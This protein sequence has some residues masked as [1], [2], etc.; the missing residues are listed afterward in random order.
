MG[1]RR[2]GIAGRISMTSPQEPIA[3]PLCIERPALVHE[4]SAE[5][6]WWLRTQNEARAGVAE[7]TISDE[8]RRQLE[9]LGY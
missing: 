2:L 4:L 8:T 9:A 3:H 7:Q 5:L 1:F 6:G